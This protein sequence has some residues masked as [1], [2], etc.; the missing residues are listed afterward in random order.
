MHRH[1]GS[2]PAE[3]VTALPRNG[4]E[5]AQGQTAICAGD[6]GRAGAGGAVGGATAHDPPPTRQVRVRERAGALRREVGVAVTKAPESATTP[7][8]TASHSIVA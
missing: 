5:S 6:G 2:V 1:A 3:R 7:T 4:Y 8:A